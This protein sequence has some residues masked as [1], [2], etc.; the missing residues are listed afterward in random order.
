MLGVS[1]Q[2]RYVREDVKGAC[3][4]IW[5]D[6]PYPANEAKLLAIARLRKPSAGSPQCAVSTRS[7][8]VRNLGEERARPVTMKTDLR[9][10]PDHGPVGRRS[11]TRNL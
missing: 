3:E 8:A 11:T 7:R 9:I 6:P 10:H 4:L 2:L 1:T 5:P